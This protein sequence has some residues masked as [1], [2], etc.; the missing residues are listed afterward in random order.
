MRKAESWYKRAEEVRAIAETMNR[1]ETRL[2]M[3][4]IARG[5]ERLAEDAER[6]TGSPQ[7]P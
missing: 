2:A 4:E 7:S 5:Y 3:F 6:R 1:P